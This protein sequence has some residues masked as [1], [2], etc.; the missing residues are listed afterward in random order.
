[1]NRPAAITA[2]V[3]AIVAGAGLLVVIG[4]LAAGHQ[5]FAV[6]AAAGILAVGAT[7]WYRLSLPVLSMAALII[8]DRVGGA[9]L[10][11]TASD[12][13]LF[14][15]FWV[16]VVFGA[17]PYAKHLRSMLW[18]TFIYQVSALFAVVGNIY[19]A[20]VV[21]WCHS[22]LLTGGA[23]VVGW[24]VGRDGKANV[25]FRIILAMSGVLAV[26]VIIVGIRQFIEL[27]VMQPVF[28]AWP[29]PMN[30]NFEGIVLAFAAVIVYARPVWLARSPWV[31]A[32]LFTVL[33]VAIILAQSR[34]GMV[35]LAV[36]VVVVLLRPDP[37]RRRNRW[38]LLAVPLALIYI[39]FSVRDQIQSGNQ[40]NSAFARLSG[41][42][43]ALTVW[44]SSPW[45]GIGLRW[46]T[47]G[48]S[49]YNFQP[50]NA[51][52]EVLTSVGLVGFVGF[53]I[54]MLGTLAIAWRIPARYGTVVVAVFAARLAQSQLD[55]FWVSIE[56]SF[57]FVVAGLCLGAAAHQTPPH[58]DTVWNEARPASATLSR[59]DKSSSRRRVHPQP[60]SHYQPSGV[61]VQGD[62]PEALSSISQ[63][64]SGSLMMDATHPEVNTR[65]RPGVE[66]GRAAPSDSSLS[67]IEWLIEGGDTLSPDLAGAVRATPTRTGD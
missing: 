54:M 46:W 21:E 6:V 67:R 65:L 45:Y 37:D 15:A 8:S 66:L 27:G 60:H 34:Q 57:P 62:H 55:Q 39:L 38:P 36:G 32:L 51:V 44:E 40:F 58:A 53:L 30:K 48:R 19:R 23:L 2:W 43:Q 52:F 14:V 13:L 29:Y 10:N 42:Q 18:L 35:G 20:N 7:L 22:W 25:A 63:G 16:A 1:M 4:A 49:P 56:V 31:A 3:A 50:P 61:P 5:M 64:R 12:M 26:L 9:S 41:F 24:A 47:A 17:R 11:L 28:L 33:T 59:A